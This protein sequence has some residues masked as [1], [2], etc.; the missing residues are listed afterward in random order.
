MAKL[1]LDLLVQA[2][3]LAW[4]EPRRPKD[5]NLRRSVS[6]SYYALFHFLIEECTLLTIGTAHNRVR[7]R[8][9][10][11]RAFVHGKMKAVCEEFVKTTPRD[12]LEPFWQS[13]HVPSIPD[14]RILAE[15]FIAL[16]QQRHA[17]D[18]NLSR[19]FKRHEANRAVDLAQEAFDAWRRLKRR[20]TEL[21]LL[22]ALALM[23]WPGLGGR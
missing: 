5:A 16:Q 22:F 21:A 8:Q 15:N 1:S 3:M 7:L 20:H 23:L 12:L 4:R 2:R 9:F 19:R 18:Y 11:G 17:A 13:L 10:A 14:V 6:A